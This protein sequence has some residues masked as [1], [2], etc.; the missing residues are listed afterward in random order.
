MFNYDKVVWESKKI[1]EK[2]IQIQLNEDVLAA[3]NFVNETF[4]WTSEM[5]TVATRVKK[6]DKVLNGY[7]KQYI[8]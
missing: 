5:E 6:A 2:I 4:V 7:V 1:L 8:F 3:E